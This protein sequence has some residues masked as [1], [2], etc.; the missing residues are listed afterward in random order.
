MFTE[1]GEA[2]LLI[3][4]TAF[5][6]LAVEFDVE[7]CERDE[8]VG[9]LDDTEPEWEERVYQTPEDDSDSEESSVEGLVAEPKDTNVA[10]GDIDMSDSESSESDSIS[11]K[12]PG[13]RLTQIN[14]GLS[15][16]DLGSLGFPGV[17][18]S[19]RVPQDKSFFGGCQ[20]YPEADLCLISR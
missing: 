10:E 9:D 13:P 14:L 11:K 12:G 3:T 19:P 17:P 1:L 7:S 2:V 20:K 8:D 15:W 4:R 5:S 6:R 16:V 18:G